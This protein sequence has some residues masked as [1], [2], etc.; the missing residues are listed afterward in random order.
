MITSTIRR[1]TLG[2]AGLLCLPAMARDTKHDALGAVGG[3]VSGAQRAARHLRHLLRK[4]WWLPDRHGLT[5]GILP[6][7]KVQAEVGYDLLM[8]G[9]DPTQFYLNGK[10]CFTENSMGKGVPGIGVGI[11]NIGFVTVP[12][13]TCSMRSRRRHCPWVGISRRVSITA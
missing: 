13:T 2:M 8:P 12:S 11:A 4:E 1:A 10:I 3:H 7:D 6:G 5:M 9:S